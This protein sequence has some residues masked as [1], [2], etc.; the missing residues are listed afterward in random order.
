[1]K[2]KKDIKNEKTKKKGKNIKKKTF[3]LCDTLLEA[4]CSRIEL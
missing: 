2:R 1:M 4:K 3:L